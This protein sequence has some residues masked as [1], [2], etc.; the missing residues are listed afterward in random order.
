MIRQEQFT[1]K[2]LRLVKSGSKLARPSPPLQIG[3]VVRF[4]DGGDEL[5]VVDLINEDRVITSWRDADHKVHELDMHVLLCRRI[6]SPARRR[7]CRL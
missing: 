6:R 3:D 5:L 4:I 2:S 1:E 7:N